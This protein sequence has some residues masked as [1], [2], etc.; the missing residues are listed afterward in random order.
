MSRGALT[1]STEKRNM[2]AQTQ[3]PLKILRRREVE[4][5]IGLSRST[6]YAKMKHNPK[7]PAEFDPDFPRPVRLGEKAVGWIEH[8][9]DAWLRGRVQQSRAAGGAK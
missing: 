8:E 1:L 4:A 7:R 2:A 3:T 5:R 6:L 9:I